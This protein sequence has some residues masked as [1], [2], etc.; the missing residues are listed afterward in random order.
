MLQTI[1]PNHQSEPSQPAI[2]INM[3]CSTH[4]HPPSHITMVK[5]RA[6]SELSFFH[7]ATSHFGSLFSPVVT[8]VTAKAEW[9]LA[10]CCPRPPST[11]V[12]MHNLPRR[13]ARP[14]YSFCHTAF[15]LPVGLATHIQAI[16][17]LIRAVL[18]SV[19]RCSTS[20]LQ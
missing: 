19:S 6:H 9:P 7:R 2:N 17:L 8:T 4:N 15:F 11:K 1:K 18:L 20:R 16:A 5:S 12:E 10:H 3:C 14:P 13:P